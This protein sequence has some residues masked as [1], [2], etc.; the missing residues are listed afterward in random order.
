MEG[1][2]RALHYS[3]VFGAALVF[4]A[5][6]GEDTAPPATEQPVVTPAEQPAAMAPGAQHVNLEAIG[7]SGITGDVH[8]TAMQNQTEVR[9][10]LRGAPPNESIGSRIMSGTCESPGVELARLDAV[11][12]DGMGQGQSVTSVGHSPNL[13]MDGNHIVA[14]YAPGAEPERDQPAACATL[15]GHAGQGN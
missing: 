7:A 8:A 4:A 10:T 9:L 2:M 12:T 13:I 6:P 1:I 11:S 15:P 3:F 14:V 5:C